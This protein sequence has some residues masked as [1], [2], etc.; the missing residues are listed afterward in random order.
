MTPRLAIIG[1]GMAAARLAEALVNEGYRGSITMLGEERIKPYNRIQLS[2][3]LAGDNPIDGLPL[4][5]DDW[6]QSHNIQLRTGDPVMRLDGDS[7]TIFTASGWQQAFDSIVIA[8]GSRP[9]IPH[10]PGNNLPG[11]MAFRTLDDIAIMQSFAEQGEKV[12]VVGGGL[13]GLEAAYGLNKLGLDVTVLHHSDALMNRQLDQ[14][15][16]NMLKESMEGSGVKILTNARTAEVTGIDQV[17]GITLEDG[18]H[19]EAELVVFATGIT[20]NVEVFQSS[21]VVIER[22]IVV[23]DQMRTSVPNIYA[24]GECAEHNGVTVGIVAPIWDQATVLTETLLERPAS[25][26]PR[27]HSTQ[28]KVSGIDVFSAGNLNMDE[29]SRDIVINDPIAGIYRRL[30]IRD[31]CLQAALLFGDKSL[32]SEYETL[33]GSNKFLGDHE[34]QL[35]FAVPA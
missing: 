19:L 35:M 33:I 23:D 25:Y 22:G 13:L 29:H 12:L 8:T 15:S 4:L 16:A 10:V 26:Q 27:E 2:T 5:D 1:T 31:N 28:L 9:F 7:R 14:H 20:P 34:Q 21:G 18:R 17:T 30:V 3:V 32:C 11:V 6:Y 24:L